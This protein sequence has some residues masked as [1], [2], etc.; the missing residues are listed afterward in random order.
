MSIRL[1][2]SQDE[3][4]KALGEQL[5]KTNK[6]ISDGA[7][8]KLSAVPIYEIKDRSDDELELDALEKNM[9]A[10]YELMDMVEDAHEGLTNIMSIASK[11]VPDNTKVKHI[12]S[13]AGLAIERMD[14][15]IKGK[16]L[17]DIRSKRIKVLENS[18][19]AIQ[20]HLAA[21]LRYCE[22]YD[23]QLPECFGAAQDCADKAFSQRRKLQRSMLGDE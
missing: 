18:I 9:S 15:V 7:V 13:Q 6:P 22:H 4:A 8:T 16:N 20:E 5:A 19:L 3:T 10:F 14:K 23:I 1:V 17:S 21:T 11:G 2:H 12:Q